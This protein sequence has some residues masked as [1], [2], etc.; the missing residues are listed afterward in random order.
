MKKKIFKKLALWLNAFFAGALVVPGIVTICT[1]INGGLSSYIETRAEDEEPFYY[2]EF[3]NKVEANP[4]ETGS[5]DIVYAFIKAKAKKKCK[6]YVDYQSYSVNAIESIDYV[7]MSGTEEINFDVAG[8]QVVPIGFKSLL[9][10]ETKEV[11]ATKNDEA[12]RPWGS[13]NDE[14]DGGYYSR[15]FKVKILKIVVRNPDSSVEAEIV[16]ETDEDY[17]KSQY[18][19]LVYLPYLYRDDVYFNNAT[20]RKYGG[21]RNDAKYKAYYDIAS[22]GSGED[23]GEGGSDIDGKKNWRS[24]ACSGKFDGRTASLYD[25]YVMKYI[26]TG[27]AKA[28]GTVL[29]KSIDNST[30]HSNTRIHVF[31]GNEPFFKDHY[32][33]FGETKK[34]DW[35]KNYPD[36]DKYLSMYI[37]VNPDV[38]GG[39]RMDGTAVNYLAQGI[40][41]SDKEDRLVHVDDG[42]TYQG[43]DRR[44]LNFRLGYSADYW[45]GNSGAL[46]NTTFYRMYPYNGQIQIGIALYNANKEYDVDLTMPYSKIILVDDV[47]P[48]ITNEWAEYDKEGN[49]RLYIRFSEAVC[50]VYEKPFM[51]LLNDVGYQARFKYGYM[52]DT[53]VY[54]VSADQLANNH[55]KITSISYEL[56]DNDIADLAWNLD[57]YGEGT[58]NYLENTDQQRTSHIIGD[59]IDL[60]IPHLGVDTDHSEAYQNS[61]DIILS[62]NSTPQSKYFTDG[63]VYYSWDKLNTWPEE[64]AKDP[65]KYDHVHVLTEEEQGSFQV[66]LANVSPGAYYLHALAVPNKG[67]KHSEIDFRSFGPYNFDNTSFPASLSLSTKTGEESDLKTKYLT[68]NITPKTETGSPLNQ[69]DLVMDLTDAQGNSFTETRTIFADGAVVS[70]LDGTVVKQEDYLFTYISNINSDKSTPIDPLISAH[71]SDTMFRVDGVARFVVTDRAG[72]KTITNDLSL[73]YDVRSTFPEKVSFPAGYEKQP[74]FEGISYDVYKFENL[75]SITF[76]IDPSDTT[77]RDYVINQ[78]AQYSITINGE[79]Y[80]AGAGQCSISIKLEPGIYSVVPRVYGGD[81]AV[82]LVSPNINFCLTKGLD[83]MTINR[84]KTQHDL[85][86]TN[87]TYQ[88]NDV[89]YYYYNNATNTVNSMNY[90]AEI[91][92]STGKYEGGSSYPTFSS[93]NAA[94]VY[95]KYLER[96]DLCLIEITDLI[97]NSLNSGSGSTTYVKAPGETTYAQP[98]QLW[99]RYKKNTWN[100]TS[101]PYSWAFYYYK[102]SGKVENGINITELSTLLESALNTITNRIVSNGSTTYLV[103]EGTLSSSTNAPY[104]RPSQMHPYVETAV[105]TMNGNT[106]VSDLRYAGDSAIYQN[107]VTIFDTKYPLATNM[108]VTVSTYTSLFYQYWG[109]PNPDSEPTSWT[110]LN[111]RDGDLLGL[112]FGDRGIYRIKEYDEKGVSTFDVYIDHEQPIISVYFNDDTDN[113]MDLPD[114]SGSTSFSPKKF[115]ITK[116]TDTDNLAYIAVFTYPYRDLKAVY[117]ASDFEN[118]KKVVLTNGNF[119][120]QVGDRSGNI[121]TYT[122]ITSETEF[123]VE[124]AENASGTGVLV[125]VVNRDEKEIYSYEVYI[126]GELK[127]NT[128]QQEA[129]YRETGIYRIVVTDIYGNTISKTVIHEAPTPEIVW[130]YYVDDDTPEKY[131]PDHISRMK[132][133]VDE[134]NPRITYVNSSARVRALFNDNNESAEVIYEVTGI[135]AD[136]YSYNEFRKMLTFNTMKSWTLRVWYSSNP[137][138]DRIYKFSADNYAP[139]Y[140]AS[141]M[142]YSFLPEVIYDD[143][144]NIIS[145]ASFDAIDWNK[146]P[147]AGD[148]ITLDTLNFETGEITSLPFSDGDTISGSQITVLVSDETGV[149]SVSATRDGVAITDL[150]YDSDTGNLPLSGYGEFVITAVDELNNVSTFRFKNIETGLASGFVD[151][152]TEEIKDNVLNYAHD[153]LITKTFA[154]G[155]TLVLIKYDDE[156]YTYELNFDGSTLTYGRYQRFDEITYDENIPPQIISTEITAEYVESIGYSLNVDDALRN[157]WYPVISTLQ[158]TLE[159]SFDNEGNISYKISSIEKDLLVETLFSVGKKKLPA[160]FKVALSKKVSEVTLYSGEYEVEE[161]SSF[162]IHISD[163]L[164]IKTTETDQDIVEVKYSYGQ[165]AISHDFVTIYD[166]TT[167]TSFEGEEKGYYQIVVTNKYNNV[168]TYNIMKIDTFGFVIMIHVMD[169]SDVYYEDQRHEAYSNH[170]IQ[171][172]VMSDAVSFLVNGEE[173]GGIYRQD[174]TVL[175]IEREGTYEVVIVGDNGIREY[176][177]FEIK[178]DET[179]VYQEDWITGF[180]DKAL[181]ADECYTNTKCTIHPGEGVIYIDVSIN[182]ELHKLYDAINAQPEKELESMVDAIGRYGNG[183]YIVGFRNRYGD[184]ILKT[185]YYSNTPSLVLDRKTTND[186]NNYVSYD[187]STALDRGFYSNYVLRFSTTS[188]KYVFKLNGE[189]YSLDEPRVLEFSNISGTGSFSYTINFLDEY[190]NDVTFEAILYRED[191]SMDLS[192]MKIVTVNNEAYTKDDI[193]VNFADNLNGVVSINNGELKTYISGYAFYADGRYTFTVSDIAGNRATYTINHKSVNHYTLTDP[194]K[195]DNEIITDGVVNNSS[196]NFTSYD[197]S[198]I[199]KVFKDSKLITGYESQTFNTTGHWEL[200]IED[201]IGNQSYESF[202]I[203]NNELESFDYTAP[204]EYEVTEV[205]RVESEDSRTLLPIS[206]RTIRLDE[207]GNYAVVVTSNKT[208]SSF[209]FTVAINDTPPSAKLVGADN[210]GVTARDVTLTGLKSGDV[211]KVYKNGELI[212]TTTVGI[213]SNSPVISTSGTYRI[214]I[215]NL[216]GVTAVYTFTRKPIASAPASVFI[217]ISCVIAMAGL[218]FGLIHHT[219]LKTDE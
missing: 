178:N 30:A 155:S 130:Y 218:T 121:T 196:V 153:A 23:I 5:G 68:L 199:R 186:P 36:L 191:I 44:K 175:T 126:N 146:Y 174:S 60:S 84:E 56:P 103:E 18:T 92:P 100:N 22:T 116:L 182:G 82:D 70:S 125:K 129:F 75:E 140:S 183:T 112:L 87:E 33:N 161:G 83:D 29:V 17:S 86:L 32:N 67:G 151:D 15:H 46:Y 79:E 123:N 156:S 90:G 39:Y 81:A 132:L 131:D 59:I 181:L 88:L 71:L 12:G 157:R 97:A 35:N 150:K 28:Y 160:H 40:N 64:K 192:A 158:F 1:D 187:L 194:S 63:T 208:T 111:A 55:Q 198:R 180:N 207:N 189:E 142:G 148:I 173:R 162:Y 95:V 147:K 215:T 137:E 24:W 14:E 16:P 106:Y 128:F 45:V 58:R 66:T 172:I 169:G 206:G 127:Y 152:N 177:Y 73:S 41:P 6:I 107:N 13:S 170:S 94:K 38:K 168:R 99:I 195:N 120:V 8:E 213:S 72:N 108:V 37:K 179:F 47:A 165:Y 203:L 154:T 93:S 20:S 144:G 145:T 201:A 193:V 124:A 76:E 122:V 163:T 209:N 51:V 54:E 26:D 185:V 48:Y 164:T 135:S 104:L 212:Q 53:L 50:P 65:S 184:L 205:W 27:F 9:T 102:A 19:T 21:E 89:K 119:Y 57:R 74:A 91:N 69:I 109:T 117:Y 167:W 114:S 98:G 78:K 25:D 52:S 188:K 216:Q 34:N 136:E 190:G 85:V 197:E 134:T 210:G 3:N 62:A 80:K 149:K 2:A 159:A 7:G 211:V 204:Y 141:F 42:P 49:L 77:T 138:S 4:A 105:K 11:L 133:I 118:N 43:S 202:Y 143:D 214:E 171:L 200:I 139:R 101:D 219:K 176:F 31:W 217:V 113:P 115:T 166:G 110:R 61:Y 10:N 96:Q